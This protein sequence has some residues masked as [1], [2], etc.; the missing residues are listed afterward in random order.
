MR[1]FM[2]NAAVDSDLVTALKTEMDGDTIQFSEQLPGV[3]ADGNIVQADGVTDL[4]GFGAASAAQTWDVDTAND[5]APKTFRSHAFVNITGIA[6]ENHTIRSLMLGFAGGHAK[7]V[8]VLDRPLVVLGNIPYQFSA[9][10]R[11]E[12]TPGNQVFVDRSSVGLLQ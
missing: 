2:A 9:Y 12:L 6:G 11:L 3:K 8:I 10:V 4:S 5:R 1:V 7:V